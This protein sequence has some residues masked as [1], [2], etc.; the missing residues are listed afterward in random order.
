MNLFI[1]GSNREKNNYNILKDIMISDDELISLSKKDIKYCLG[2]SA[3]I[4]KLDNYC[5]LIF[6]PK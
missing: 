5:V 6:I 2:C 3:C 1:N 4:N